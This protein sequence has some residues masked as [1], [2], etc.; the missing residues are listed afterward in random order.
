MPNPEIWINLAGLLC[1]IAGGLVG[2]GRLV[3]SQKDTRATLISH[4]SESKQAL[5]N[6]ASESKEAIT[7]T[8]LAVEGIS[9]SIGRLTV[10][11]ELQ[12]ANSKH[13]SEMMTARHTS[14]ELRVDDIHG[15]V[16]HTST[17]MHGL[18]LD[19]AR[20]EKG[21]AILQDRAR[22]EADSDAA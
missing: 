19:L 15:S 1:V 5:I 7:K 6:H 14:L 20:L 2:Y 4:A 10:S 8:G 21:L 12:A 13:L 22:I 3:Q 18:E 9:N 17:K 16:R 11:T